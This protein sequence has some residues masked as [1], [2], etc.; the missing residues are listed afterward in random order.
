MRDMLKLMG[1][2]LARPKYALAGL[3]RGRHERPARQRLLAGSV[4][5]A[6]LAS[7]AT[8]LA[9]EESTTTTTTTPATST[10]EPP[11]STTTTP[12]STTTPESTTTIPEEDAD[13]DTVRRLPLPHILFP[14]VGGNFPFRDTFGAPRD[15]GRRSHKGTDIAAPRGTQVVAVADGTI[16]RMDTGRL[17]GQYITLRH[18]DG[19]S[20]QYVHLNNDSPGTDDGQV[21]GFA[22]GMRVGLKVTAGTVIGFVGD[23]GNAESTVPHLHFELH[24]PDGLR[25]NP[26]PALVSADHLDSVD[27]VPVPT[28]APPPSTQ[29]ASAAPPVTH[30]TTLVGHLDPDGTGFNASLAVNGG[31]AYM[32]TW[33]RRGRC[34]GTGIRVIDATDPS[35]PVAVTSFATE[36]DYPGTAAEAIWVEDVATDAFTGTIGV[37]GLSVCDGGWRTR[38]AVEFVGLAIYDLSDPAEPVLLSQVHSGED[39]QGIHYVTLE[40]QGN[41]L[42]AAATVPHSLLHDAQGAGDVRIYDLTD[43]TEPVLASDWD[44]RRDG[45]DKLAEEV[46]AAVGVEALSGHSVAWLDPEHLVVAHSAAG[47]ITLDVSDPTRPEYVVSASPY[48]TDELAQQHQFNRGHGHN[49]HSGWLYDGWVLIQDDQNL[50]LLVGDGEETAEWGQQTF[51]D[52]TD[53]DHPETLGTFATENSTAGDDGEVGHDGF[54]SAHQSVPFGTSSELVTWFSDGVRVVDLSD[55]SQPEEVAYFVPP[56][57]PDPQ[58][59]WVAPDGT[60]EFAMVWGAASEDG[61]IFASDLNSGLWIFQMGDP[62]EGTAASSPA[63]E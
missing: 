28:E 58:G 63:V 41:R 12:S 16:T 60:R 47:L 32:G 2:G 42:L 55:P 40:R 6:L 3:R 54:Y 49:A 46:T 59:W 33:G 18:E 50:D 48:E 26:Y 24:Q 23:S 8:A 22:D 52:F 38:A 9:A 19:W 61:L 13:E 62:D 29:T 56:P 57:S 17:A 31:F 7:T 1:A 35:D 25:I 51:Y 21:V 15:G 43:P 30:N 11:T 39:T 4:A 53:P 20:S 5:L 37:V 44:L 45:P 36:N 14:L 34:P 27:G 10:T